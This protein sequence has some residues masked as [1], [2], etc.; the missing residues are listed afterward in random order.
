M[1]QWG[2][3]ASGGQGKQKEEWVS[4]WGGERANVCKHV[5]GDEIWGRIK[6][7]LK[8]LCLPLQGFRLAPAD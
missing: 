4:M 7:A 5:H 1:E 8:G 3:H 6:K 2:G